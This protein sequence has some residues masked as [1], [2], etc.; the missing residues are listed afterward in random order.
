MNDFITDD[1]KAAVDTVLKEALKGTE[2]ANFEFPLM[3]KAG[4]RIDI[5]LNATRRYDMKGAIVGV[6]GI[7]Q[8]ITER[9]AQEQE[10]TRVIDTANAPIFGVDQ[11]GQINIWNRKAA[12]I[13]QYTSEEVMG[14]NLV[15]EFITDDFK[16]AVNSVLN[17]ALNGIDTANFEFPLITKSA[18]RVE[19]LLNATPRYDLRGEVVGVVGIGQDI[20]ERIA[21]ENEYTRLIDSANAPIFGVDEHGCV[22]IW[23]RKAAEITQ[24]S[25]KDVMGRSLVENFITA[26]YREAVGRVLDQALAG[27]E[28][29][30]FEFPLI[31]KSGRRVEILLNATTRN[32]VYGKAVGVVGIGQDIT[33]RIAQEQQYA[34]LIDSANAPIFGVDQMGQ[35]NICESCLA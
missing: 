25:S 14:R 28:S 24:Y 16:S 29:S 35:I 18:T 21:Q 1:Y 23:N 19:I 4:R 11:N 17:Q 26:D 33:E 13:M 20:T 8:D 32:N 15:Q 30:N 7:G 3:T 12:E 6:V 27:K 34:R 22:N 31:T 10:Y 9:I 2:T 5:L